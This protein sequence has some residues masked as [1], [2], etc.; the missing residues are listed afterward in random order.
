MATHG[1]LDLGDEG[2]VG[3]DAD[4]ANV[5]RVAV[6]ERVLAAEGEGHGQGE[7]LGERRQGR[8]RARGPAPAAG[9]N[10]RA[11]RRRLPRQTHTRT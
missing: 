1:G 5:A 4:V 6:V 9:D 2:R 3:A 11:L 10:D 8:G 7:G